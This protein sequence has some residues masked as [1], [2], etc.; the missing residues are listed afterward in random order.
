M[1]ARKFG[2]ASLPPIYMWQP[3]IGG[4][5]ISRALAKMWLRGRNE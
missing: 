1:L 2:M 4:A 3:R 5:I